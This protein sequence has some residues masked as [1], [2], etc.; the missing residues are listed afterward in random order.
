MFVW[1]RSSILLGKS[2]VGSGRVT[3]AGISGIGRKKFMS[4]SSF[5]K[6]SAPTFT[7][8][9]LEVARKERLDG[10]GPFIS[11]LPKKWIPYAELM[12]LSLIHI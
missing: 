1:C 9:E 4:S 6:N 2:I 5:S 7:S 12:R 10:L 3:I 11:R 8:K